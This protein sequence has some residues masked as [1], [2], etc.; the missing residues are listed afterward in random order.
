[1]W[2]KLPK[3]ASDD[4]SGSQSEFDTRKAQAPLWSSGTGDT[5]LLSPLDETPTEAA[6]P[7]APRQFDAQMILDHLA[8]PVLITDE[9][10]RVLYLNPA[11]AHLFDLDA[12]RSLLA[13]P[14]RALIAA[15]ELHFADAGP[16]MRLIGQSQAGQRQTLTLIDGRTFELTLE[17][18]RT[19]DGGSIGTLWLLHDVTDRQRTAIDA[20]TAT[21]RFRTLIETLEDGY[22][23]FD[24]RG[25][26]TFVNEGLARIAGYT[27]DEMIGMSFKAVAT[28]E[29]IEYYRGLFRRVWDT[30][31]TLRALEVSIRHRDGTLRTVEMSVS[32]IRSAEGEP[33]GFRGIVRDI[34]ERKQMD[35]AIRRRMNLLGIL[36]Q[37]NADLNQTLDRDIMLSVAMSAAIVLADAD[38]GCLLLVEDDRLRV[39]RTL[40]YDPAVLAVDQTFPLDWG[41]T[42]RALRL[43]QPQL[44]LNSPS[45]PDYSPIQ[46][47]IQA[48]I[49]VPLISHDAVI[50][51]LVL[52][53]A[54]P[55]NF[56][57][58]VVDLIQVLTARIVAA[59][60]NV[61]LYE[62]TL[63]QLEELKALN[64]QL[65]K[66]EAL[67][68]DVIHIASHN[69]RNPIGVA[70]G[71]LGILRDDLEGKLTPEQIE[72]FDAIDRALQRMLRMTSDILSM[73]AI[74]R[75]LEEAPREVL[76]LRQMVVGLLRDIEPEAQRRGQRLHV[77]LPAGPVPTLADP[78][79]LP[80]AITNLLSNAIKYTPDGGQIDVRL[81]VEG[82]RVLFEVED[83]GYG[84]PADKQERLF[85][86][87]YRAKTDATAHIEG[88]GL[89]LYLVKKIVEQHGGT[90]RFR[91]EPGVGSLFGFDLPLAEA[92]A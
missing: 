59:W 71:Y 2:T 66:V 65:A 76:D 69:L 48:T 30:Q 29:M 87:F 20:W 51:A 52:E 92:S 60:D 10:E 46:P 36:Q 15:I 35:V 47:G 19:A 64:A 50:G 26:F 14:L 23:E 89:G 88:T 85:Q 68:T 45:D 25:V 24:P 6:L 8:M 67:K 83:T 17:P 49:A 12:A 74:Q 61:H 77:S 75:R 70:T 82:Q 7:M 42:G 72:Y 1:M 84:I 86:P 28:P 57:P 73:E 44:V 31:E 90:M 56:D 16:I 11:F 39:V 43:C 55:A 38:V 80:E 78:A 62:L 91:S 21:E 32:L 4:E 79:N 63:K 37:V 41:I 40:G 22:Y 27:R 3:P 53:T 18:A 33:V 34:T 54:N 13:Q 81:R 58:E 5:A 9:A